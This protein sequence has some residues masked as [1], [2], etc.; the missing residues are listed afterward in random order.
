MG[1]EDTQ[2]NCRSSHKGA[3]KETKIYLFIFYGALVE[4]LLFPFFLFFS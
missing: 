2:N 3:K 1:C 4:F